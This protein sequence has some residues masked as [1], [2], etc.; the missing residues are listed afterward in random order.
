[1]VATAIVVAGVVALTIS[2]KFADQIARD[3]FFSLTLAGCTI[4][5]LSVRSRREFPQAA[6]AGAVLLGLQ[7]FILQTPFRVLTAFALLGL[8]S[9]LLLAVRRIWS[10]GNNDDRVL[11]QDATLPPL[12]FLLLGYLGSGP[13]VMTARL[14]PKTLDWFLYSFDQSL[15]TQL[16]F[17]FGQVVLLSRLLTRVTLG[18]YYALPIA[19][20]FTYARQLV[21]NRNL[22]MMAFLAFAVAGPL[23]VVFYNLVPAGG[24]ANLFGAKFP[25]DPLTTEQLRQIPMEALTIAGPRNAFPSLHLAW[26]LLIG[27]YAEG[28]SRWTKIVF[29]VFVLGT[30]G[31]TLALG[32]HYFIDLV[33]AFPFALMIQAACALNVSFSDS[34]RFVPLLTGALLMVAWMVLLRWGLPLVW[35]SPIV[36]WTLVAG[37]IAT[38]LWLQARL[39]TVLFQPVE[40]APSAVES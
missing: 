9:W 30:V 18:V 28:L 10:T 19:I 29:F 25:F 17:R 11:L 14:H 34:R 12:L 4:I 40:G 38:T 23:G 13:L 32:E 20:M 2:Q 31:S 36:P 8:G 39:R 35:I 15:G 1:M 33:T 24:P 26:A 7:M 37:T 3:N 22:A 16:S 5:F 21:R 27:W 6:G